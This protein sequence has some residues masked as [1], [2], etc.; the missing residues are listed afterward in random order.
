MSQGS[1]DSAHSD[2]WTGPYGRGVRLM[3]KLGGNRLSVRR[4][5]ELLAQSIKEGE[6]RATASKRLPGESATSPRAPAAGGPGRVSTAR[7]RKR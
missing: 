2:K 5:E 6:S 3:S 1:H 4:L 7:R